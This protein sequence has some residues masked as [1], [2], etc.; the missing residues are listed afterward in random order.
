LT[1]LD[2]YYIIIYKEKQDIFKN[3]F[4]F[5]KNILSNPVTMGKTK[6]FLSISA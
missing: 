1:N 2:F 5:C 3:F 4:V 6:L